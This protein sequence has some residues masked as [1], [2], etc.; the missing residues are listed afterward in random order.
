MGACCSCLLLLDKFCS[1]LEPSGHS[2]GAAFGVGVGW[3][4]CV[5]P[6]FPR[7]HLILNLPWKEPLPLPLGELELMSVCDGGL[8][9]LP[10]VTLPESGPHLGQAVPPAPVPPHSDCWRRT[11]WYGGA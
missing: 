6:H 1:S 2:A 5:V 11:P 4:P 9:S 3:G 8:S 7:P 10:A